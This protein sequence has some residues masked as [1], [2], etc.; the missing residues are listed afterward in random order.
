MTILM[1]ESVARAIRA[2]APQ[3]QQPKPSAP[4]G[5]RTLAWLRARLPIFA[6][7]E[8]QATAARR[9]SDATAKR[10]GWRR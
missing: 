8:R 1:D 3:V 7:C 5:P 9:D 10:M 4:H 2:I 6:A